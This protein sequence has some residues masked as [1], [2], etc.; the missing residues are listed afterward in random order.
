MVKYCVKKPFTV[1]VGVVMV[2]VLG[3]ISFTHLTKIGRAS[4]RERV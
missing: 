3:F 2:L 4:C 1:L